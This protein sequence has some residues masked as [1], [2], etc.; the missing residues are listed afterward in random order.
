[1]EAIEQE[2]SMAFAFFRGNPQASN[3]RI[4]SES[5]NKSDWRLPLF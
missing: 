5:G 3:P 1:M 2:R 4:G